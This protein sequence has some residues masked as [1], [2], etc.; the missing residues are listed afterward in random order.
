[1]PAKARLNEGD[2]RSALVQWKSNKVNVVPMS[3]F[4]KLEN[5]ETYELDKEYK[6]VFNKQKYPCILKFIGNLFLNLN[7]HVYI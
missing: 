4:V 2:E 1:M 5:D 3:D 7:L 6:V